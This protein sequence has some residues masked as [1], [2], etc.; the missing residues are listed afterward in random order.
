MLKSFRKTTFGKTTVAAL[1]GALCMVGATTAHALTAEDIEIHGFFTAGATISDLDKTYLRTT[2]DD[3]SFDEDSTL[4]LQ[5]IV[6]I[7]ERIT[8]QA[9][10]LANNSKNADTDFEVEV[11]W[12]FVSYEIND[13]LMVRAGRIRYPLLMLGDYAEV[14]Y[15]YPWIRPPQEVYGGIPITSMDGADLQ[16]NMPVGNFNLALQ[17]FVG[18]RDDDLYIQA[19]NAEIETE[20]SN[21]VGLKVSL[22]NDYVTVHAGYTEMEVTM[23]QNTP[24]GFMTGLGG[25]TLMDDADAS[26]YTLG[27]NFERQNLVIMAEYLHADFKKEEGQDKISNYDAWYTMVGYRFGKFMPHVTLAQ[28]DADEPARGPSSETLTVG[29]RYELSDSSAL[30]IEWARV[31]PKENT[32]GPFG[33][34]DSTSI[35]TP[36]GMFEAPLYDDINEEGNIFSIAL[37]VIF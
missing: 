8:L 18:Q 31:E 34:N 35:F 5:I 27:A 37:E 12:A 16:F 10:L 30:K 1:G 3:V 22:A 6:P 24:L 29:L 26:L 21:I 19:I 2:D 15:A 28:L 11:D 20:V 17:P 25:L 36:Y 13:E 7:D 33:P 23:D 32:A 9:Q 14:G 4:G